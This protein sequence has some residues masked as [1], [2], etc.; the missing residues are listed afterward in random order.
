LIPALWRQRLVDLLSFE[1]II[2]EQV[3]LQAARDPVSKT[4][5]KQ[6]KI[7][8]IREMGKGK[9]RTLNY[10]RIKKK[11]NGEKISQV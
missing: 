1:A 6:N 2:P 3:E 11:K 5:T 10:P 7:I 4:K 9:T 8:C